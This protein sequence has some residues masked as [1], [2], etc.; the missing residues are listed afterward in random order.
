MIKEVMYE[1]RK[2]RFKCRLTEKDKKE[3]STITMIEC[4]PT[5]SLYIVD[6]RSCR[7]SSIPTIVGRSANLYGHNNRG[8]VSE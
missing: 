7:V 4:I 3:A 6:L 5:L 8:V 2:K 1:E